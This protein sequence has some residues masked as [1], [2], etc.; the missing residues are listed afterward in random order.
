MSDE[1]WK[2][3]ADELALDEEARKAKQHDYHSMFYG[4]PN[5]MAVLCDLTNECMLPQDEM[6]GT[7]GRIKLLATIKTNCGFTADSQMAAIE[8]E[9]K[10]M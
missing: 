5:G 1:W 4:R 8:A 10:M 2:L 3:S 9:G 7:L 6:A